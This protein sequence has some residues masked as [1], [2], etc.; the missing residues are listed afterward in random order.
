M[1]EWTAQFVPSSLTLNWLS[2]PVGPSVVTGSLSLSN[3]PAR[4]PTSIDVSPLLT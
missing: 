2:K 4:V 1:H 3:A